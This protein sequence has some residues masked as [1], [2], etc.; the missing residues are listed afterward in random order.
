MGGV[1]VQIPAEDTYFYVLGVI[2]IL[3]GGIVFVGRVW[4]LDGVRD[5]ILLWCVSGNQYKTLNFLF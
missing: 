4:G 2:L 3:W 1:W 5:W